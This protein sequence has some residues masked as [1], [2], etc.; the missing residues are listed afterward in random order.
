MQYAPLVKLVVGR[1]TA[2]LPLNAID[3]EDLVHVGIIGLMSALE[4]FDRNRNVQFETYARFRIRGAV[5]D[6]LRERDWVPRSIRSK[7]NQLEEAFA[8]LKKTLKR[9]PEDHEVAG[10]L[11]VSLQDYFKMLDDARY[12]S[13]ISSEDLPPEYLENTEHYEMLQT[14]EQGNALEQ[15]AKTETRDL[16]KKAID[17]LPAKERMVLSLYYYDELNM[18]EIGKVLELTES[19]VCQ[20]HSQAVLRLRSMVNDLR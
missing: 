4:K 11:N 14:I 1:I 8:A 12:I 15:M 10:Y 20:L 13:I 9:I 16:L 17:K 7:D 6:E 2:K 3:R 5:L 18:K 19:R